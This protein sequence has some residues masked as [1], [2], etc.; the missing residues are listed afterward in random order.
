MPVISQYV[1]AIA[2]ACIIDAVQVWWHQW[3]GRPCSVRLAKWWLRWWYWWLLRR[4]D[5]LRSSQSRRFLSTTC[6]KSTSR[7]LIWL[8]HFS[9]PTERPQLAEILMRVKLT[10]EMWRTLI[11]RPVFSLRDG[12][13]RPCQRPCAPEGPRTPASDRGGAPWEWCNEDWIDL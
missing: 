10:Q 11:R 12:T 9:I 3:L 13:R 7:F 8:H 1:H 4:L 6:T 5:R 2:C